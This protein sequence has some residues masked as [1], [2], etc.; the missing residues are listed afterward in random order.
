MMKLT[1][2][3]GIRFEWGCEPPDV[4]LADGLREESG[5]GP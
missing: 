2:R 3:Y 5:S 4:W 1:Q